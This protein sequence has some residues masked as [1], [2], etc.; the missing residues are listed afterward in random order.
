MD[1]K[2]VIALLTA[3]GS[4]SRMKQ[5]IPKQF[6]N[7]FD[8]PLIIYTLEAFQNHPEVDSIFVTCIAGWESILD[9]YAKQFNIT[10]LEK[11][12]VGGATGMQSIK[13]GLKVMKDIYNEDDIVMIHDGNRPCLSLEVISDSIVKCREHNCAVAV[14]PCNEAFLN[15]IEN[16][17]A[18]NL[19]DRDKM[20]KTQTPHSFR[21]GD[22]LNVHKE[23]EK[24]GITNSVASCTLYIETGH[25]IYFSQGS[26]L[27]FKI[28]TEEDLQIFKALLQSKER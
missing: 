4:G 2:K 1:N 26:E 24:M 19:F 28:T 6:M 18:N 21:L 9:A 25:E 23:A 15:T 13:N 7:I 14:V 11:I 8:K 17:K 20:V 16:E 5:F 22:L 10:K 27:N 3:G 12:V